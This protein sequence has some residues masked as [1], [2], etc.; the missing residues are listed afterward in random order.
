MGWRVR[1]RKLPRERLDRISGRRG[2]HRRRHGVDVVF[3]AGVVTEVGRHGGGGR[4]DLRAAAVGVGPANRRRRRR[5]RLHYRRL[6]VH[7]ARARVVILALPQLAADKADRYHGSV[8]ADHFL[9]F[10][11][12]LR[13]RVQTTRKSFT[14]APGGTRIHG[15]FQGISE[16]PPP[17]RSST[18]NSRGIADRDLVLRSRLEFEGTWRKDLLVVFSIA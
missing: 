7:R 13:E 15:V 17:R 2:R 1:G 3:I 16:Y 10:A 12:Q 11:I 9:A 14:A 6:R 4:G 5:R 8:A 18:G